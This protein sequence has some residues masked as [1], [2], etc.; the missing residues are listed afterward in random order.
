MPKIITSVMRLAQREGPLTWKQYHPKENQ[1]S[2][3]LAE[4]KC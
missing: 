1:N 3:A 4:L 2:T